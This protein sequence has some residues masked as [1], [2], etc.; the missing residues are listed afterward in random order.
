[1]N[2]QYP[3]RAQK[4]GQLARTRER[5]LATTRRLLAEH[6]YRGTT[7]ERIAEDSGV[8]R[9]TIYR[10]WNSVAEVAMAAFEQSLGEQMP[11]PDT[12]NVR[13]DLLLVYEQ[14]IN[15]LNK[16]HWG[17][18]IPAMVEAA[19]QDQDF[20]A[21]LRNYMGARRGIL[22]EIIQRGVG[23]GELPEIAD[24]DNLLD[25]IVGA[26]Y[27]R[28][29]LTN[30]PLPSTPTLRAWVNSAVDSAGARNMLD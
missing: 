5:V 11:T 7:I 18:T 14:M 10:H 12:G 4:Q 30:R 2:K 13:N 20:A 26:I 25:P 8:A 24:I 19:L 17:S 22:R 23:R 3:S 16:T 6:G 29:L 15:A 9:S 27:Y 1:M 28:L 21:L